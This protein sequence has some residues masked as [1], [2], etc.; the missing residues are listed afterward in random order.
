M[1]MAALGFIAGCLE[2]LGIPYRFMEWTEQPPETY[3][4]GEY[5]EV[6]SQTK[7]ENGFQ[8]TSFLLNGF[9]RGSWQTLEEYKEKI[10]KNITKTA[11]LDNGSGIAVFY[12]NAF[13]VPTGDA[14][15]KRIQINL[16][17]KEWSVI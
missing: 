3:F 1:S 15:L 10:E 11:I 12:T 4:V 2:E 8:E 13:P 6:G 7:Q 14:E 9:T 17:I 5:T 16:S